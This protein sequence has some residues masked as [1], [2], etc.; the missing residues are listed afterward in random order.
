MTR[1]S[2]RGGD[3]SGPDGVNLDRRRGGPLA[4]S[5][6]QV[7]FTESSARR[8]SASVVRP[9][10]HYPRGI[11][12]TIPSRR[13]SARRTP[14]AQKI[15]SRTTPR[16]ALELHPHD[17]RIIARRRR[18]GFQ[19]K[20]FGPGRTTG[21]SMDRKTRSEGIPDGKIG[22]DEQR[23]G[24]ARSEKSVS[25]S[26]LAP[27]VAPAGQGTPVDTLMANPHATADMKA[28]CSTQ[29]CQARQSRLCGNGFP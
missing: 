21:R 19:S 18:I 7:D 5:S 9:S 4:G 16:N 8:H 29:Q 12:H 22:S 25:S 10:R 2:L 15:K 1:I 26:R 27:C 23:S 11:L 6:N 14:A 24:P 3:S 20:R 28:K 17:P 13:A